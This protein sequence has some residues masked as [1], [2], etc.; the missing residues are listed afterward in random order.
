MFFKNN[1]NNFDEILENARVESRENVKNVKKEAI[2][3]V[4]KCDDA[5]IMISNHGMI[6]VCNKVDFMACI[7][8][9]ISTWLEEG[10][11]S[12]DE[13][14]NIIKTAK[15]VNKITKQMF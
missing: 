5:L 6:T 8:T 13:L 10:M 1:F 4:D 9:A 7:T 12:Y 15:E 3:F 11:L 2:D 14:K